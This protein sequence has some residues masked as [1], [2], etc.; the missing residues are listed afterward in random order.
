MSNPWKSISLSDYE[1]HMKLESI[2]QLQTLNKMMSHQFG[3]AE[4]KSIIILGIAGGNGLEHINC[5]VCK[6]VYGIDVNEKYLKKCAERYPE[7]S[8]ILEC[9]CADLTDTDIDL[10]SAEL[11]TADLLIEYIGY[12]NFRSI[13]FK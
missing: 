9:I 8:G 5:N 11:L 12:E 2:N 13:K 10:P 4:F 1:N 7:M 6:K 3:I